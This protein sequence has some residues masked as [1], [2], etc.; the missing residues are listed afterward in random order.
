M[1]RESLEHS[2]ITLKPFYPATIIGLGSSAAEVHGSDHDQAHM[3]IGYRIKLHLTQTGVNTG[4]DY[5]D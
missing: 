3:M 1:F 4:Y 5:A 2:S